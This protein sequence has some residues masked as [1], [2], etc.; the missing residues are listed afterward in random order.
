M[1]FVID[2]TYEGKE[3][4]H[5]DNIINEADLNTTYEGK[6]EGQS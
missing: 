4:S 3:E 5:D 1:G 2:I 6:E